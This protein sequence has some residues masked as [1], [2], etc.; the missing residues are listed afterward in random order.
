M[1]HSHSLSLGFRCA[2]TV[3]QAL[4]S[5]MA[6]FPHYDEKLSCSLLR[7]FAEPT[8]Y[9]QN[10]F[11]LSSCAER[12]FAHAAPS[13]AFMKI[14]TRV[15]VGHPEV[16]GPWPADQILGSIACIGE[17]ISL[18]HSPTFGRQIWDTYSVML[19]SPHIAPETKGLIL[20]QTRYSFVGFRIVLPKMFTVAREIL[21]ARRAV[22][23]LGLNEFDMAMLYLILAEE[24]KM[25]W[26]AEEEVWL[27]EVLPALKFDWQS[28]LARVKTAVAS[29]RDVMTS[30][31]VFCAWCLQKSKTAKSCSRCKGPSYCDT[32]CQ[33]NAWKAHHKHVC[34]D[35]VNRFR[36]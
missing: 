16:G 13:Q 20:S 10:G 21:A 23:E 8:W 25:R 3:Y 14:W 36:T 29:S 18:H 33:R 5:Q 1:Y 7:I 15:L 12:L 24:R 30:T 28:R 31:D 6:Q 27:K 2:L 19:A 34:T 9:D 22:A 17:T 26:T 11:R 32:S 4:M 35:H